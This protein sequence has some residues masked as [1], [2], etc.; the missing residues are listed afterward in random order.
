LPAIG[1]NN[2]S[3]PMRRLSPA[4]TMMAFSMVEKLKA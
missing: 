3:K 1:A 2:L 4:A